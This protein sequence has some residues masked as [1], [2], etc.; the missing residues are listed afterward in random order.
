MSFNIEDTQQK[1]LVIVG[2]GFAGIEL[3]KRLSNKSIQIVLIDRHNYHTFQP[4]LYQVAT[5]GLEPDSIA[6]P[7]RRIFRKAKNIFFRMAEVTKVDALES[8][9]NTTIGSIK[10]DFLVFATGST[11]NFHAFGDANHL[12][13]PLKSIPDA[14]NLRSFLLQ[15]FEDALLATD[16]K[17]RE[18]LI[19]VA[20]AGGG[21]TG[22]ELAGALG[23]M[24]KYV[25][26]RDY[27][28]LDF[29]KMKIHL[30]ESSPRLLATLSE[31][32]SVRA[33]KYLLDLDIQ[34]WLNTPVQ[35]YDGFNLRLGSGQTIQAETLIWTA[36]V[37][38][39]TPEGIPEIAILPGGRLKVNKY[40]LV[41]GT[42][43]IYALGDVAAMISDEEPKG[44]PM[45]APVAI[46]QAFNLAN[47]LQ[48]LLAGKSQR[49][50]IYK[51]RG[52]MA[53]V[54][55]NRAVVELKRVRFY[56]TT[57]WYIWMFVHIMS[58]VGFR[59]RITVFFNWLYNYFTYDRALR[60]IIR[61]YQR[62]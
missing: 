25:L 50:F 62:K 47:N 35:S 55:R 16:I 4:L 37:K 1:R 12:L 36:G 30:F 54:G 29:R 49:A 56:G 34:I 18:G 5:G 58:L 19:N 48:R 51:D 52:T 14:L 23:E 22:V 9:V 10:Y 39:I 43:N 27:P 6:Y 15:N 32:S 38:V 41:E 13:M 28:E 45:L 24:K 33:F 11:T 53:T 8:I 61:P 26:P 40:H 42:T 44:H 3:A 17:E 59:N 21:P 57:A 31:E 2:G 60:L 20:I 46:Q 7:L